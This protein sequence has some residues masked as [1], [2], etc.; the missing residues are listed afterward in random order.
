MAAP[1]AFLGPDRDDDLKR[2]YTTIQDSDIERGLLAVVDSNAML[3]T[4][5]LFALTQEIMDEDMMAAI[6][7]AYGEGRMLLIS[8]TSL[9]ARRTVIWDIAAI[10]SSGNPGR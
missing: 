5:P 8:T 7:R 6:A 3:D 2:V 9:D 10:A 1:F 4:A